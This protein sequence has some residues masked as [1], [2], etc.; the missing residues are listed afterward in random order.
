MNIGTGIN[1]ETSPVT[2]LAFRNVFSDTKNSI[3]TRSP[4]FLISKKLQRFSKVIRQSRKYIVRIFCET[5]EK[6]ESNASEFAL[7]TKLCAI[8]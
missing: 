8:F 7:E 4:V 1:N 6:E 2:P 3:R 5:I